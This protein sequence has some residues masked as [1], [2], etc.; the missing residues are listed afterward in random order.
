MHKLAQPVKLW[1]LGPYFR[2]ER[3]QHGRY[4][5]FGQVGV[6]GDRGPTTRPST[7]RRSCCSPSCSR[8]S[9][10]ARLRVSSLGTPATRAEYGDEL[11]QVPA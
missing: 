5:Q 8:R 2:A 11:K 3:P 9:G 1:Y 7:P 10:L 6:V 4:R